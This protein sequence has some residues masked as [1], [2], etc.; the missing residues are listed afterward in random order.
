MKP[1]F[2]TALLAAISM[3]TAPVLAQECSKTSPAHTV[4]LFELY[5]SE[6]CD[7][8]PAADKFVS[9]LYKSGKF[10]PDQVLAL[11]LHVD[12]WDYIGWKD[13]YAKAQF[14]QRQRALAELA[15]SR[16][17]YTPE[18]FIGAKE[19]RNWR[20]GVP[21]AVKRINS[22]PAQAHITIR[23]DKLS[24]HTL[25]L[26]LQGKSAQSGKLHFALVEH[27]LLN[28][29]TAGENRGATLLHDYVVRE[30]GEAIA[31]TPLNS[32]SFARQIPLPGNA[33]RKNLA[34]A[35]FIQSDKG[36]ILQ[37]LSLPLCASLL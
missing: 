23:I 30:W 13:V 33:V 18:V 24:E 6:G 29:I 12:Y 35:A 11:A 21:D 17:V 5:T 25:S 34:L 14:S 31:L 28:K 27:S 3:A 22:Q 32:D 4:A 10:S 37:A 9:T 2:S 1:R 20:D 26:R 19:L 36:T 16:N 7:S 8:C 15:G